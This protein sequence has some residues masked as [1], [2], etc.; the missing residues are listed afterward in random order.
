MPRVN[1]FVTFLVTRMTNVYCA[2]L[3]LLNM[4]WGLVLVLPF[5]KFGNQKLSEFMSY[6]APEPLW[7]LVAL[8]AGVLLVYGAFKK[9]VNLTKWALMAGFLVWAFVFFTYVISLPVST[10]VP[11]SCFIAWAHCMG[12]LTLSARPEMLREKM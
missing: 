4:L 5:G 12:H 1:K 6:L 9:T 3:G 2:S 10:A 11:T 7:G 8:I